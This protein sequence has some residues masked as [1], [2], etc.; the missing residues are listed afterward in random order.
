MSVCSVY[1][2]RCAEHT[3]ITSQ[4]YIG[5]SSRFDRRMWEHSKLKGNRHLKF[6]MKKY[7]WDNLVK[8]QILIA[9]EDYCLDIEHKLRPTDD[10]G[11][12]CVSGGGKPPINRWNLG[13]KGIMIPWN[14]GLHLS[15]EMRE[16]ISK[17]VKNL[18]E[19]TEYRE[20]MSK[21][22]KGKASAM[23]GK[24]HSPETLKKMSEVK[25]GK[26]QS[27]ETIE[28]KVMKLKGKI[29]P[30]LICPHCEVIGGVGAMRRWHFENCKNK[31]LS[32]H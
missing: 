6:A 8:T 23:K 3:D 30:K 21:V 14:K 26:K 4:G 12:N 29:A 17:K 28:K 7:G 15:E 10:I 13:T 5:V 24:K 11:W 9:E 20:H 27:K 16:Q 18:W 31:E 19:N 25:L 1:W 32:G 22:H 2:I